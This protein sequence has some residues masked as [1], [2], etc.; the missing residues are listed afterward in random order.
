MAQIGPLDWEEVKKVSKSPWKAVCRIE[1]INHAGKK[2]YGSGCLIGPKSIL[3]AAHNVYEG[4]LA[5]SIIVKSGYKQNGKYVGSAKGIRH[6]FPSEWRNGGQ[7]IRFDYC[8]TELDKPLGDTIGYFGYARIP[9][10][11]ELTKFTL[12][13]AGYPYKDKFIGKQVRQHGG[14]ESISE[15]HLYYKMDTWPG[16]SGC[17]TFISI[18]DQGHYVVGIHSRAPGSY[19]EARR[20]DQNVFNNLNRWV[21]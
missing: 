12:R 15:T 10:N 9:L 13:I 3:T 21:R 18:E 16:M 6:H 5:Q 20:I 1:I 19:N 7:P 11:A 17:P 2:K 8:V 14:I 4:G